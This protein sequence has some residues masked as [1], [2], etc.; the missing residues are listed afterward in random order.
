MITSE[1]PIYRDTFEYVSLLVDYVGIMPKSHRHTLGQKLL[2][3]SLELFEYVQLANRAAGDKPKR[4]RMLEGFLIKFE[5]TK[6][7]VRLCGEKMLFNTKQI[8]RLAVLIEAIG[9]QANGWKNKD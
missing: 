1:L 8:G 5:L 6:V 9:K 4:V 2:N 7:L 3:V